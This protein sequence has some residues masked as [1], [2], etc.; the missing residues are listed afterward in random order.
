MGTPGEAANRVVMAGEDGEGTA[1]GAAHVKCADEAVDTG[2]SDDG[3]VILVPVVGKDFGWYGAGVGG[4]ELCA[5]A[6]P[7]DTRE[8]GAGG[9]RVDGNGG[10]E[11]VFRGYGG[12]E[13]VDTDM[14]VGRGSGNDEGVR[15]AKGGA[16]GAAADREGG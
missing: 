5:R 1:R 6:G 16:V 10:G 13:I 12:A 14:G 8:D 2:S 11:V 7:G 9:G 15:G 3:I 4:A